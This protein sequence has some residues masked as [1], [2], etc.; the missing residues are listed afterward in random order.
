MCIP[1]VASIFKREDTEIV[2]KTKNLLS[3]QF[4]IHMW[5]KLKIAR[6]ISFYATYFDFSELQGK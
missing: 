4:G 5:N 3:L 2:I 1:D 6:Q